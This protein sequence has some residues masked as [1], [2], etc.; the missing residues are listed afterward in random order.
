[1]DRLYFL[2]EKR[3][4]RLAVRWPEL[5]LRV[6]AA[7]GALARNPR[8][9]PTAEEVGGAFRVSDAKSIARIRRGVGGRELRNTLFRALV[10]RKSVAGVSDR[11]VLVGGERLLALCAEGTPPIIVFAHMGVPF[12]IEAGLGQLGLRAL[13]AA[14]NPPRRA[15]ERIRFQKV[16]GWAEGARFLLLAQR[17]LRDGGLPMLSIDAVDRGS[18]AG[19]LFGRRVPISRGPAVLAW[20]VGAPVVP[21]SARWLGSSGHIEVRVHDAFSL[22]AA[23]TTREAFEA[24][25]MD[26]SARW[27]EAYLSRHPWELR[28]D[29]LRVHAARA[30]IEPG[31][32]S[33]AAQA[34]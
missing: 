31:G 12:A 14:M 22:P 18:R 10:N 2:V 3:L 23:G 9:T 5:S 34:G 7:L 21:M 1:L 26:E 17:E 32:P 20:T 25:V 19:R 30:S 33:V 27:L 15:C 28:L 11:V 24:A 13:V 8:W 16:G 6:A 4:K 29:R